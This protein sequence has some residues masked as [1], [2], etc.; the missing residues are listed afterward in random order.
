ME[1]LYPNVLY[2]LFAVAIPVIVHLFNFRRYQKIYFSN[3][4]VL[5]NI[6]KK[7]RK[8]SQLKHLIILLLRILAI[9][10]IVIA[11]AGPIVPNAQES[12][13]HEGRK[14]ISIFIDNSYSMTHLGES[15]SLL[16]EAKNMAQG[17]LESYD[18][19]D[20]FH[21]ITNDMQAKHHRWFNK[22]EMAQ[23][24]Q[25]VEAVYL[26]QSLKKIIERE[27]ILRDQEK[28][29]LNPV[30][31]ILSDFQKN[32]SF[33]DVIQVDSLLKVR[34]IP[35]Q[36][37]PVNNLS[38]D[39]L[40]FKDPVQLPSNISTIKVKL[41]NNGEED[42]NNIPL[43]LLVNEQQKTLI[44]VELKAGESE[45]FELS[46]TN[47]KAGL[48]KGSIEIEDYPIIYDDQLYF[49][50]EVRDLFK[51]ALI[52]ETKPNAFL[53]QLYSVDSLVL[54]TSWTKTR[55][56]YNLLGQQDLV[57]LD[58]ISLLS[59]GLQNELTSY[60]NNG[61]QL[62]LIPS[63]LLAYNDWLR[64]NRLPVYL[65]LKEANTFLMEIDQNLAF[66][67]A[68]FEDKLVTKDKNQ[69]IDLPAVKSYFTMDQL[70]SSSSIKLLQS[71]TEEPLLIQSN[72]GRGMVYQLAFP[73]QRT[74]SQLP[75][76]PL[77]VPVFY[78][79]LLQSNTSRKLYEVVGSGDAVDIR[80]ETT[81][82][83]RPTDQAV[84]LRNE[85]ES[86]IPEI[87]YLNPG[88]W[89]LINV[90]WPSDGY[91]DVEYE[92]QIINQLAANYNRKESDFSVWSPDELAQKIA[93]ENWPGF[94]ILSSVPE[95]IAAQIVQMDQG[96]RLWKWFLFFAI[97]FIFV[98]TLILR[99]WK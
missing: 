47:S 50:F 81:S 84:Y 19:A 91:F 25:E 42:Q 57:I 86:W 72:L 3:V 85:T 71:R 4:A 89:I 95:K 9:I 79:M 70:A 1:F 97:I 82:T 7:T 11:F 18:N 36:N 52:Y 80:M 46:F 5:K 43:K 98:E 20:Q 44:S 88:E 35:L 78:Q 76:H 92:E 58:E 37:N 22:M 62:L 69:K 83:A 87:R 29:S 34:L 2:G 21:L 61:G 13:N 14:Q 65:N 90:D 74:Y 77:F 99:L 64:E 12:N 30:L 96:V 8:Q 68:V 24:I 55:V 73:L 45:I 67:N 41:S 17:I 33:K 49:T 75:E 15:G 10:A 56:D 27:K 59:T 94:Q 63:E 53:E 48:F 32:S 16:N 28:S 40:W 60:V 93:A 26:Q 66:F 54:F 6:Q 51:V 31:Y 38:I 23:N 39:S